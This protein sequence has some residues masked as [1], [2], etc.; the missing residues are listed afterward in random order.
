[1]FSAVEMNGVQRAIVKAQKRIGYADEHARWHHAAIYIGDRTLCEATFRGV[2]Y[3]GITDIFLNSRIR[4]RRD[5]QLNMRERYR[6]A[7][8]AL[9]RLTKPYDFLSVLGSWLRSQESPL[10]AVFSRELRAKGRAFICS[11][12][13]HEAY[14]EVTS[15]LLVTQL[16]HPRKDVLPPDLSA[17][18]ELEDVPAAW[19]KLP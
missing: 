2:R 16:A 15:R 19:C 10:T 9:M 3:H 18:Q 17:C 11:E 7:I 6:I 13:Y 5:P 14:A 4:I 12:L 8:R 1:M